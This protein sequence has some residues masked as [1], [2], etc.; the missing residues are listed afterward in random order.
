MRVSRAPGVFWDVVDGWV[1]VCEPGSGEVY[2][3]NATAGY[4]WEGCDEASV[5]GLATRLAAVFP[6]QDGAAVAADTRRFVAAMRDK[7]L[8]RVDSEES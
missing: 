6:D 1:T 8:L 7:G 4:L 5:D 2:R 3:L